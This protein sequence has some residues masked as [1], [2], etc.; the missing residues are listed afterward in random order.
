MLNNM[1]QQNH[2]LLLTYRTYAGFHLFTYHCQCFFCELFGTF[3]KCTIQC[4][5]I[6]K[7]IRKAWVF[8][9]DKK[10]PKRR[11]TLCIWMYYAGESNEKVSGGQIMPP[12]TAA[13]VAL[14]I[15]RSHCCYILLLICCVIFFFCIQWYLVLF[16]KQF[17]LN[18]LYPCLVS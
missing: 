11:L 8:R 5:V 2:F 7:H 4:K 15:R 14:E 12:L 6:W 1:Q 16:L 17:S 18:C 3:V 13:V 9:T 10:M